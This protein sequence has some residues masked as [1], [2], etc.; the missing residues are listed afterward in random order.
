MHQAKKT[1]KHEKILRQNS[2]IHDAVHSAGC[3]R[4]RFRVNGRMVTSIMAVF[5][6]QPVHT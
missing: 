5:D 2:L 1:K 3:G 4:H 6:E